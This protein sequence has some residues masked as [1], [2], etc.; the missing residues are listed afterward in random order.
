MS[1]KQ[2]ATGLIHSALDG[3][4]DFLE[5]RGIDEFAREGGDIDVLVPRNRAREALGLVAELAASR[6][7]SVAGW[8]DIGYITQACL[9]TRETAGAPRQAVKIDLWN[10]VGWL[11][12]GADPYAVAL[13]HHLETR[14]PAETI[15]L[16]TLL[17]KLLYP[18]YLR[19]R[20]RQRVLAAC[21]ANEI[22]AFVAANSIPLTSADLERDRLGRLARWRLRAA[23]AGAANAGLPLW[24]ARIAWRRLAFALVPSSLPGM[25]IVVCGADEPR[26]AALAKRF[27]ALCRSSGFHEPVSYLQADGAAEAGARRPLAAARQVLSAA[28]GEVVLVPIA[29][30]TPQAGGPDRHAKTL[31][32]SLPGSPTEG[33]DDLDVLLAAV[34]KQ[35][36]GTLRGKG[37]A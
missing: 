17:Q 36:L 14:G 37:A 31:H 24:L 15:G 7:W 25:R 20:D 18:G 33:S 30:P 32:V 29:V 5:L 13:F 22:A 28:R 23:S 19:D 4:M 16:V 10:G 27:R 11:G 21:S 34:T 8:R 12:M 3:K 1:I 2:E 26:R 9:A 6:G 35:S